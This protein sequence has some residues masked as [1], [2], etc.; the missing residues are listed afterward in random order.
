[1][2]KKPKLTNLQP[3]S[4]FIFELCENSMPWMFCYFETRNPIDQLIPKKFFW[5]T[6]GLSLIPND[7]SVV[8]A[9]FRR[10]APQPLPPIPIIAS[11]FAASRVPWNLNGEISRAWESH[12]FFPFLIF[13][14]LVFY[15]AAIRKNQA[16]GDYEIKVWNSFFLQNNVISS[17]FMAKLKGKSL[18]SCAQMC[19]TCCLLRGT[20]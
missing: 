20:S 12:R 18:D 4:W 2:K 14:D 7:L 9:V 5:K 19:W 10:F 15:S 3:G 11:G 17:K 6:G 13:C 1:M 8:A 16:F